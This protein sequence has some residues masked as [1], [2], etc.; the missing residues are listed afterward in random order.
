[1]SLTVFTG[2]PRYLTT[3]LLFGSVVRAGN[4]VSY[5]IGSRTAWPFS[6]VMVT[7]LYF[8]FMRRGWVRDSIRYDIYEACFIRVWFEDQCHCSCGY[9]VGGLSFQLVGN[10]FV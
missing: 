8:Y 6:A 3:L 10:V 9:T 7:D 1:M 5:R 4:M 2:F